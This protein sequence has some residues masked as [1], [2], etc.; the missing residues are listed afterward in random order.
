MTSRRDD[1]CDEYDL[2]AESAMRQAG[3]GN[4]A[5]QLDMS[6]DIPIDDY[7]ELCRHGFYFADPTRYWRGHNEFLE[8]RE[9]DKANQ[10]WRKKMEIANTI[11]QQLGGNKFRM[12]T[13]AKDFVGGKDYLMFAVPARSTKNGI[14]KVKITLELNDT[15]TIEFMKCNFKNYTCDTIVKDEIVYADDLQRFFTAATGLDTHL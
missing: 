12:M 2:G 10:P 14:N 15:Y 4:S 5:I 11:L 13:G 3:L 8:S 1:P 6:A 7:R 9:G